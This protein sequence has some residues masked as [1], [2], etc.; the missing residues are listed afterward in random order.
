MI[1]FPDTEKNDGGARVGR[2]GDGGGA[3]VSEAETLE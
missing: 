3:L 1:D 2:C